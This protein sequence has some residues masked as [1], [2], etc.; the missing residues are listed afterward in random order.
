MITINNVSFCYPNFKL[1]NVNLTIEDGEIIAI[2]GNN[3]SGKTTL[4]QLISGH[5]KPKQGEILFNNQKLEKSGIRIGVVFQNPDNQIIFNSVYDDI[6]FTLKN[7]KI[8]KTE[9]EERVNKALQTV[10]M[11]DF[12]KQETSN[13]STGQKQRI[14]IA[15]MLAISPNVL[16]FDEVTAYLDSKTKQIIYNLFKE[17]KKQGITVIFTTNQLDEIVYADRV[18]IFNAGS[19]IENKKTKEAIKDLTI[20]KDMVIPLK[21]KLINLLNSKET[22]DDPLLQAIKRKLK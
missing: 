20:F 6:C 12:K 9:F 13:L 2:T 10:N 8:P 22:E 5:I 17:L 19:L 16:L 1:Q 4:L 3:G 15:N 11:L 7:F 14:V 21:L 18:L